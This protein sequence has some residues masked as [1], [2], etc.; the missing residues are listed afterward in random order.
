MRA[1]LRDYNKEAYVVK[2]VTCDE[3]GQYQFEDRIISEVNVL[4]ILDNANNEFVKCTACDELI[5]NNKKDIAAHIKK[6]ESYHGCLDCPHVRIADVQNEKVKMVKNEDDTFNRV[7]H[8]NVHLQCNVDYF[9]RYD[10]LNDARL[11][12][13]KYRGCT[14]ETIAHNDGFFSKYPNAFDEMITVDAIKF[15]EL[16]NLGN[17]TWM[18]LKCRGTVHAI[19]NNKGIIDYFNVRTRY[20]NRDIFYSKKYNELFVDINGKYEVFKPNWNWSAEK[21]DYLKRT[22]ANLYV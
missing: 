19:A 6:K 10:I 13:C 17:K 7:V 12:I 3:K 9:R 2:D 5:R 21:I 4:A 15:K 22:I 14:K 8:S 20:D 11:S 18:K 1:I 16:F